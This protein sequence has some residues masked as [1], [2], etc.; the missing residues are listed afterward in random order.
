M[1]ITTK[2]ILIVSIYLKKQY[3]MYKINDQNE[4]WLTVLISMKKRK[5]NNSINERQ[6]ISNLSYELSVDKVSSVF[7]LI[8]I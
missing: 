1:T 5:T 2:S 8:K 6:T 4:K 3:E 7:I